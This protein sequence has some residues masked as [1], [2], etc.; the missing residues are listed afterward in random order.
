MQILYQK[1]DSRYNRLHDG[2]LPNKVDKVDISDK[3][4]Q[5]GKYGL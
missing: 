1:S 3:S 2:L 5:H 4:A